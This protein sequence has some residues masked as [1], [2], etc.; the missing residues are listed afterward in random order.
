MASRKGNV[1]AVNAFLSELADL[2]GD[3]R[4]E[5]AQGSMDLM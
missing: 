4:K 3:Y 1:D 5:A 2:L